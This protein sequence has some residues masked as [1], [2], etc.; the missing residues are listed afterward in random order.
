[1]VRCTFWKDTSS[2]LKWAG[3]ACMG[4]HE[5]Q[6]GHPARTE[7]PG[8]SVAASDM[9]PAHEHACLNCRWLACAH[10][11]PPPPARPTHTHSNARCCARLWELCELRPAADGQAA[12]RESTWLEATMA[13]TMAAAIRPAR[14][15]EVAFRVLRT[16]TCQSTASGSGVRQFTGRERGRARQRRAPGMHPARVAASWR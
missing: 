11:R 9:A 6:R 7:R 13:A 5:S 14:T 4:K 1:V 8:A 16:G 12:A 3:E 15:A 2:D 10:S